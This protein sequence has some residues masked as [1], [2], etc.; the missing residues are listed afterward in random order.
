[1]YINIT[2]LEHR[3]HCLHPSPDHYHHIAAAL[4]HATNTTI[5]AVPL[6]RFLRTMPPT[7]KTPHFIFF[8]S[9]RPS[10]KVRMCEVLTHLPRIDQQISKK[11][12]LGR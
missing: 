4:F 5:G 1:M 9:K 2:Y 6:P 11:N 3:H 12:R 7:S 10:L 8:S